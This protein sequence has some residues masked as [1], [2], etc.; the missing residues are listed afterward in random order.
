MTKLTPLQPHQHA[1]V[2]ALYK[3]GLGVST[4]ARKLATKEDHVRAL[5][6]GEGIMRRRVKR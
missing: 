1:K 3:A 6:K 4:I 2:I 5:I